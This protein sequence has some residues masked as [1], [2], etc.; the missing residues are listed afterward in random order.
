MFD[1]AGMM[2]RLMDDE[3]LARTVV[4]GY[5]DD[6]P[7]QIEA[8]RGYLKAG[9]AANTERQAHTIKGAS[10]AV[11]GEALCALAF[12]MEKAAKAGDLESVTARLPELDSQFALLKEALNNF[13][14]HIE[15]IGESQ[16]ENTHS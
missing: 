5:L 13:I 14:K 9:D 6:M 15:T 16:H 12:E 2:E 7:R 3:D 10:V 8:L 4:E 11:G 1:K